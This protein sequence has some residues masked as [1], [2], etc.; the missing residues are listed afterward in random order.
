[1]PHIRFETWDDSALQYDSF[2]KKWHFYGTVADAMIQQLAIREDSRV[3]ELACGTGACTLRLAEIARA[4]KVVA[5]DFSEKMLDVATENAKAAGATNVVFVKGD[6]GNISRLLFGE[7][8]D[9]AVCNSAFWHFPQPE[10]VLAGLHE[11]LTESGEFALSLPSWV[12]KN[13]ESWEAFRSKIREVLAKHG[14]SLNELSKVWALHPRQ[15]IDLAAVFNKCGFQVREV[16]FEFKVCLESRHDWRQ[17]LAFSGNE[18]WNGSFP[19]I[20][21]DVEKE[22]RKELNDWRKANFPR[23]AGVSKWRILVARPSVKPCEG[24]NSS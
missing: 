13:S 7:K 15:N 12:G 18:A 14:L 23:D 6:A 24:N 19:N 1:M 17:I 16:P 4:G 8:F 9:F 2:E 20:D 5:L 3:L 21:P 11:L 10:N 22:I